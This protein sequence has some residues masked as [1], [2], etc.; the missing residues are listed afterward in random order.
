MVFLC[1]CRYGGW[2][3]D[4]FPQNREQ[5]TLLGEKNLLPDDAVFLKDSSE[6]GR[7]HPTAN[8]LSML[9]LNYVKRHCFLINH[10]TLLRASFVFNVYLFIIYLYSFN[11]FS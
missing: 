11:R 5:W 10:F 6:G 4:N 9:E 1:F 3:L 8:V 2:I 7:Y